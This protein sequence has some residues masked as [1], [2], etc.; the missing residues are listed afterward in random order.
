MEKLKINESQQ[1][2]E[3]IIKLIDLLYN[4]VISAG[5]DGDALWYTRFFDLNEIKT[6]VKEY[7]DTN[8]IK[9]QINEDRPGTFTWGKGEEAAIFTD[10][11]N[12]FNSSPDWIQMKIIY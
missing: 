11:I 7:N 10:D 9:W 2:K 4:E 8:N 5:G 3:H 12:E 6:I 1:I